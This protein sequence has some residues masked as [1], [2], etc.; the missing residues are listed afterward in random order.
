MKKQTET[1]DPFAPSEKLEQA[2]LKLLHRRAAEQGEQ[3]PFWGGIP[4]RQKGMA[5]TPTSSYD[6]FFGA[7]LLDGGFEIDGSAN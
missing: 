6:E 2:R 5:V 7:N 1:Y 4:V 3:D